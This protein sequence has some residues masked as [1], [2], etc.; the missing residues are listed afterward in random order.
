MTE[1]VLSYSEGELVSMGIE[2]LEVIANREHHETVRAMGDVV[3]HGIRTGEVLLAIKEKT[4][5]GQW[6]AWLAANFDA[7]DWT[8]KLYVRFATY[9]SELEAQGILR[10]KDA[11]ALVRQLAVAD[12]ISPADDLAR[13][14]EARR[15]RA[16]G[17]SYRQI[18]ERL[19]VDFKVVSNWINVREVAAARRKPT[20]PQNHLD[21]FVTRLS[22]AQRSAVHLGKPS[23]SKV[24]DALLEQARKQARIGHDCVCPTPLVDEG[25]CV[26]CGKTITEAAE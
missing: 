8:A 1:L 21:Q 7:S 4:P 10:Y 3:R 23:W 9:R 20:L 11:V 26:R 13:R 5:K 17:C 16:E 14:K 12:R 2:E 18:G 22:E 24:L 6:G 15:L 19:G 25:Q